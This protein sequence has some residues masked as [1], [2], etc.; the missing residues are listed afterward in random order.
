[1][2]INLERWNISCKKWLFLNCWVRL[3]DNVSG[4]VDNDNVGDDGGKNYKNDNDIRVICAGT[5]SDRFKVSVFHFS[6]HIT[7]QES[8]ISYSY[9]ICNFSSQFRCWSVICH[10]KICSDELHQQMALHSS[11][12]QHFMI[13]F[14]SSHLMSGPMI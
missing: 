2:K 9:L 6:N 11:V 8:L 7:D 12:H 13:I 4:I 10:V 5:Q 14:C 1:M 3:W